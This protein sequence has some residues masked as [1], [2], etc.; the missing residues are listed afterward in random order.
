MLDRAIAI[1]MKNDHNKLGNSTNEQVVLR[2]VA[3][4]AADCAEKSLYIFEQNYPDNDI[5]RKAIEAGRAFGNGKARDQQLRVIAMNAFKLGKDVDE[6]SKYVTKAAQLTA[7]VAYTH[8]DLQTG[9][10]GVR[11]AQHILGPVVF[12]ALAIEKSTDDSSGSEVIIQ[13]AIDTAP[14]E[15]RMILKHFPPQPEGKSR[16]DELFYKL[17]SALRV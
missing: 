7:A 4:W 12:A 3:L 16:V 9:I 11:Q 15:A 2:S 5:P 13:H 6:I 10:Q 1:N 14:Q 8:T 17:D